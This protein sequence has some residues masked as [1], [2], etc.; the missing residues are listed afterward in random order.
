MEHLGKRRKLLTPGAWGSLV[1]VQCSEYIST[2]GQVQVH[3]TVMRIARKALPVHRSVRW[4][5][6]C[7]YCVVY[8]VV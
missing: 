3:Y 7:S 6:C 8:T 4:P 5:F 2:P 1:A